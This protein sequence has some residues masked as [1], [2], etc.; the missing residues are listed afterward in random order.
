MTKDEG[1]CVGSILAPLIPD[2]FLRGS[3]VGM[4]PTWIFPMLPAVIP[5]FFF[6]GA[7]SP[8]VELASTSTIAFLASLPG[9]PEEKPRASH[10]R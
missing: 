6:S 4:H 8:V 3:G 9:T 2:T 1:R 10:I 7:A 5:F